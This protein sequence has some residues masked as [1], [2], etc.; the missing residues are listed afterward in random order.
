[1][2]I[3]N[4]VD[5]DRRIIV[6]GQRA[7]ADIIIVPVPVDPS[8]TP[9]P[10]MMRNPIPAE[11]ESPAPA[12]VVGRTPAPGLRGN[13]RPT[14]DRIP[15]PAAVI[16]RTPVGIRDG[17]HP[18]IAVSG[19]IF[20]AAVIGKLIFV[21]GVFTGQIRP[22]RAPGVNRIAALVPVAELITARRQ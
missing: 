16:I 3:E 12:A 18:D 9:G 17:R 21:I 2:I 5:D 1:M 20:P 19:F 4:V 15:G 13:P 7:P 14:D 10:I 8:R 11:A 22:I 6:V